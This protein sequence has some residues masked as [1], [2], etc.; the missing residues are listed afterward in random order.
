[1]QVKHSSPRETVA[2][3]MTWP[4]KADIFNALNKMDSVTHTIGINFCLKRGGGEAAVGGGERK[5]SIK[6]KP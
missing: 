2:W 5:K 3:H 4:P 6:T 1:M